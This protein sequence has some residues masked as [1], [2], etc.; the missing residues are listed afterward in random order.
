MFPNIVS[1]EPIMIVRRI[2]Q[3]LVVTSTVTALAAVPAA[4]R[5]PEAHASALKLTGI[6]PHG[7]DVSGRT[8]VTLL[9][10]FDGSITGIRFG[11][12]KSKLLAY[13]SKG[14]IV[15]VPAHAAGIVHVKLQS[16]QGKIKLASPQA[17]LFTYSNHGKPKI[18]ASIPSATVGVGYEADLHTADNRLGTW[19]VV[20]GQL[21]DGLSIY[22]GERF[23]LGTPTTPGSSTFTIK[24]THSAG[25]SASKTM[26][27]TVAPQRWTRDSTTSGRPVCGADTCYRFMGS[28][29]DDLTVSTQAGDGSWTSTDVPAPADIGFYDGYQIDDTACAATASCALVGT[30][31]T[32]DNNPNA[33]PDAPFAVGLHDGTW[34]AEQ[35]ADPESV[36][37][38]VSC[39]PTICVA[40]GWRG[41]ASRPLTGKPLLEVFSNGSWADRQPSLA[42]T[43]LTNV[44]LDDVSCAADGSCRAA[45]VA[46][47]RAGKQVI[48]TLALT[49]SGSV[50]FTELPVPQ[51][52][53]HK[54]YVSEVGCASATRCIVTARSAA[55]KF[56]AGTPYYDTLSG[57]AWS[58][59]RFSTPAGASAK[60]FR[61]ND[62]ECNGTTVC[63][64]VGSAKAH[65]GRRE[66]I[67]TRYASGQLTHFVAGFPD[68][69]V[70]GTLQIVS[71]APGGSCGAA[72]TYFSRDSLGEHGPFKL[73]F[74][75]LG[76]KAG[77]TKT[78]RVAGAD[79]PY[80]GS[81]ACAADH[82]VTGVASQQPN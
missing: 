68:H 9:G 54:S 57:K 52:A 3:L 27:I 45:G 13:T 26:H 58:A 31:D 40:V 4:A 35:L 63:F 16:D 14:A 29:D 60:S 8:Q 18:D 48:V 42:G 56:D 17:N 36:V 80:F 61:L 1:L 24:L 64:V 30:D 74:A 77:A 59:H 7:A 47:T 50:S 55:S 69:P 39:A 82:C 49:K 44:A 71:C 25:R 10:N 43:G 28:S 73:V 2:V 41:V 21:P 53:R 78:E 72:G 46:L 32:N 51:S 22:H 66:P 75:A 67:V 19:R 76:P 65:S 15:T 5:T 33:S 12:K 6:S 23:I 62:L 20:A 79:S 70:S 81:L 11:A 34:T 38:R 37:N